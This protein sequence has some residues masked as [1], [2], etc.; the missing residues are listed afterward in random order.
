M[1][2]LL[3]T[4][5]AIVL[6]GELAGQAA[7]LRSAFLSAMATMEATGEVRVDLRAVTTLGMDGL[8]LVLTALRARA[9]VVYVAPRAFAGT[10]SLVTV[11]TARVVRPAML[12]GEGWMVAMMAEDDPA[13]KV[14]VG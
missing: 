4:T 12:T 11:R 8:G 9:S 2:T 3:L 6:S 13:A 5:S 14:V 1:A 10:L 7:P